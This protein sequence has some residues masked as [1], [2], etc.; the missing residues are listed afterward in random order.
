MEKI[1]NGV[2]NPSALPALPR[3]RLDDVLGCTG[4]EGQA[5]SIEVMDAA[6][7]KRSRTKP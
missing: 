4:Y 5:K 6:I 1:E 2:V 3:T 7:A